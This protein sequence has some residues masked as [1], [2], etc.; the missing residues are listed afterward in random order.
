MQKSDNNEENDD[1]FIACLHL[2]ENWI[3]YNNISQICY[4]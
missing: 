3:F 4:D 2:L 1:K